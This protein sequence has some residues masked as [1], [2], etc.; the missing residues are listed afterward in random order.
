[1]GSASIGFHPIGERLKTATRQLMWLGLAMIVLGACALVFPLVSTFAVTLFVGGLFFVFGV[2][3]L[4]VAFTMSGAG[5]FFGALLFALASIGA[6][7]FLMFNPAAGAVALTLIVGAL[8][9]VQGAQET[10]FAFEMRPASGWVAMLLSAIASILLAIIIFARWPA[11]SLVVLGVLFGVNF[12]SS[13]IGLVMVS[14][15]AKS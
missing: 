9:M 15:A 3:S 4:S 2:I 7:V 8:F 11:I 5:P 10:V 1:M 6:G 12:I 13:G 14:R